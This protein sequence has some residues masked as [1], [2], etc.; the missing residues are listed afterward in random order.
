VWG[1]VL[2]VSELDDVRLETWEQEGVMTEDTGS[3]PRGKD[4]SI[5][6]HGIGKGTERRR[7][8]HKRKCN[9]QLESLIRYLKIRIRFD[10]PFGRKDVIN[11]LVAGEEGGVFYTGMADSDT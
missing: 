11:R 7:S 5:S 3:F 10:I 8:W 2:G 9:A 1:E 6:Y 4:Q